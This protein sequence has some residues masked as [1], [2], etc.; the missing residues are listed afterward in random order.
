MKMK[1]NSLFVI[2]FFIANKSAF[3]FQIPDDFKEQYLFSTRDVEIVSVDKIRKNLEV[4]ANYN[5]VKIQSEL[6]KKELLKFLDRINVKKEYKT[7][8]VNKLTLNDGMKSSDK[9]VGEFGSCVVNSDSFDIVFDSDHNKIYFYISPEWLYQNKENYQY[10]DNIDTN[11]AFIN[12]VDVYAGYNNSKISSTINDKSILG[13]RYGYL[14]SNISYSLSENNND[15]D[16]KKL[17]YILDYDSYLIQVGLFDGEKESNSTSFL[18]SSGYESKKISLN[19]SSSDNLLL[20]DRDYYNALNYYSPTPGYITVKKDDL[21][22]YQNNIEAG[23][24]KIP[25]SL[26]PSGVYNVKVEVKSNGIVSLSQMYYVYNIKNGRLSENDLDYMLSAGIFNDDVPNIEA[27]NIKQ[28]KLDSYKGS[29]FAKAAITYGLYDSM[30]IGSE[31]EVAK[32]ANYKSIIGSSY[33]FKNNSRLDIIFGKYKQGSNI[34]TVNMLTPWFGL[35]YNDVDLDEDDLYAIYS[36]GASSRKSISIDKNFLISSAL[37]G[38][39]MYSYNDYKIDSGSSKSWNISSNL[40]YRFSSGISLSAQIMYDNNK[41][42]YTSSDEYSANMSL[43]IPL[44]NDYTYSSFISI[45]DSNFDEFRNEVSKDNFI[46]NDKNSLINMS[47]GH[48]VYGQN[49]DEHKGYVNISGNHYGEKVDYNFYS[50][51]DTVGEKN[52]NLSLTNTQVINSD[53]I[54]F[55]SKESGSYLKIDVKNNDERIKNL[56]LITIHNGKNK[57]K[58]EFLTNNE[59]IIPLE[60]Y[61]SYFSSIDTES[62]SLENYGQKEISGY[63][64]PGSVYTLKPEVNKI[65]SFITAFEDI[66]DNSIL[67][68]ACQGDGCVDIENIDGNVFNVK[69]RSGSEFMLHSNNLVCL[70]PGVKQIKSLNLGV[71]YC[72]PNIDDMTSDSILISDSNGV[73]KKVYFLGLFDKNQEDYLSKLA[74]LNIIERKYNEN[75]NLVFVSFDEEYELT[76]NEHSLLERVMLTADS[77]KK[78]SPFV[79]ELD[80]SW[81]E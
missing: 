57:T 8:I 21:I 46:E 68:L 20:K 9:C 52:M 44:D 33:L 64:F 12:K 31:F 45:Y 77:M 61:N 2:T 66:F 69:V 73:K 15:F 13:L 35:Y 14:Q 11:P 50:Y 37:T 7:E 80:Q 43:I 38:S 71:N 26:L 75:E 51:L 25:Y 36:E 41:S 32:D 47:V 49:E 3:G 6:S 78:I 72:I 1:K 59:S 74:S 70:T 27:D 60:E 10:V 54:F 34:R 16:Y 23:Q 17:A 28:D 5:T 4:V 39:L 30:M 58:K 65:V 67:D 19:I 48:S 76:S 56:G 55:T 29:G 53:G 40:D 24:G 42:L 79:L 22:I 81:F 62:V 18:N 63:T